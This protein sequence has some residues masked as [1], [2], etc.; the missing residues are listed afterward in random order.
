MSAVRPGILLTAFGGP[1]SLNAVGPFMAGLMHREP[2]A[3]AV[4]RAQAKYE[5]IGGKSPLA[6]I[7]QRIAIAIERRLAEEGDH[8]PVRV[9]MRYWTPYIAD[10]AGT[11]VEIGAERL[12]L[13]SL[14]AFESKV[15]SG[16]YREAAHD[17]AVELGISDVCEMTSLHE[18]QG[19]RKY[20]SNSL[21]YALEATSGAR[22]LVVMTAHSL[23]ASDLEQDDP[24]VAGLA[25]VASVVSTDAGLDPA[26]SIDNDDRLPGVETFGCL[27]GCVPWV[28]AYQSKGLR[29]GVWLE[30]DLAEVIGAAADVGYDE[31]VVCPI[32][33]ATDHMETLY[34]LDIVAKRQALERG[35]GFMRAS[36]PNDDPVLID[37]F[38]ELLRP[39]IS[40]G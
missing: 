30:P 19:F 40:E 2:P 10:A 6:D 23:P 7:A 24:Y 11:L 36:V 32:G 3:E 35:L 13:A 18:A 16:A 15:A 14:S 5:A 38:V 20:L 31:I 39:L 29:P 12:I 25:D 4:A 22:P 28:F 26:V 34:D 33:F 9:G 37:A 8:V 1:D 27:D 17:A 21:K